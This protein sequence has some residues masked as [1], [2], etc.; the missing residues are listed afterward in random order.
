MPTNIADIK[1]ELD[2]NIGRPICVTQQAGRKRIIK[3]NGVLSDTFPSVFV[4]EL[5]Q[6][7]N[8]FERVCYSYTDLLTESVEIEF[9]GS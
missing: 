3:R 7:E 8:K 1:Q 5:D 9:T 6:E 4:V 2:Q